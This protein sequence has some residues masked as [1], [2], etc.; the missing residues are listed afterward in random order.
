M[1]YENLSIEQHDNILVCTL[2]NPP[3]HTLIHNSVLELHRFIDSEVVQNSRV[4]VFTGAG[5]DVFIRHY[6][7]GELADSSSRQQAV[8][9]P[10]KQDV[11]EEPHLFNQLLLK[12]RALPQI[13]IAAINGNTAGGGCEFSLGCDFRLM[14]DGP[15]R[16]G[17]PETSVGIIPGAAGTQNMSRLLGTAKALELILHAETVPPQTALEL[18]LVTQVFPKEDFMQHVMEFA[19]GLAN[20]SPIGLAAAK[21][22]IY[23]GQ[24][25]SLEEGML[26]EQREF[27]RTMRTED[28]LRAM[29]T[30]LTN[31][32]DMA[33]FKWQGK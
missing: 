4:I 25:K 27:A 1:S 16:I 26:I 2:S 23:G 24:D 22:A 32:A 14:A 18:G 15:Y 28:A 33:N 3:T 21:A 5:E 9:P 10:P 30:V 20:R 19:R 8:E 29:Q 17:L 31:P 6:E 12:F 13:T 7:V 11:K